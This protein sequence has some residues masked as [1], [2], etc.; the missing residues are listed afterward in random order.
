MYH[1]LILQKTV[2][3]NSNLHQGNLSEARNEQAQTHELSIPDLAISLSP[4][5]FLIGWVVFFLIL[6]KIRAFLDEKMVISINGLHKLPC[7]KCRFYSNNHYLKCAVNPSVVLTGEAMNC[8]E[9]SPN[10]KK[11]SSKNPFD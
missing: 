2:V 7:K 11:G 3:A 6:Q 10:S 8:S 5:G 1:D 9:Y 4:V